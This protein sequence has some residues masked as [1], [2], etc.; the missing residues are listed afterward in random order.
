MV[1]LPVPAG[2]FAM[3]TSDSQM[4]AAVAQ[5]VAD[6]Y[7]E[8][9]CRSWVQ[10]ESPQHSVTLG[11]LWIDRTEVSNGQ[12][13]KCVEAGKCPGAGCSAGSSYNAADQPV[14]CVSWED[15]VAYCAWA[16]ARLPTEAEWE[17]AARGTDGWVYPWGN[18]EPDCSRLNYAGCI[19]K[20]SEVGS[21][22]SGASP[23]GALDM[24]GNVWEWV[25]DWYGAGYYA[26]SPRENPIGPGSGEY[27]VIRGGSWSFVSGYVRAAVRSWYDPTYLDIYLGFRCAASVSPQGP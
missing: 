23:Y 27:R 1:M 6:G 11:D 20:P 3:G 12:Y 9:N 18:E 24:A 22:A 19:G 8:P 16:G 2:E 7:S 5:C 15:A 25:S 21:Y 26:G 10:V 4:E 14:V 17:K 13:Q